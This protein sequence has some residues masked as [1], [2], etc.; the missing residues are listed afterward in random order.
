MY[1]M[2]WKNHL[3][4]CIWRVRDCGRS[5]NCDGDEAENEWRDIAS[6][7]QRRTKRHRNRR[8]E[9][10]ESSQN[11]VIDK[12]LE[13]HKA[14]RSNQER[15]S[16]H[17]ICICACVGARMDVVI[18]QL[19]SGRPHDLTFGSSAICSDTSR[20]GSTQQWYLM[21]PSTVVGRERRREG[22]YYLSRYLL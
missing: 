5:K 11:K 1:W 15:G 12:A 2:T 16:T 4:M 13:S 18:R 20:D 17:G 6:N 22:E 10:M 19:R 8:L 14:R 3:F 21:V 9:S 7:R